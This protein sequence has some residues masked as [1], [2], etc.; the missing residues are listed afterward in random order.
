M[1]IIALLFSHR[2]LKILTTSAI[3]FSE[4]T[5]LDHKVFNHPV[6]LAA[7]VPLSFRLLGQLEE[8][9]RSLWHSLSEETDYNGTNSLASS[10]DVEGYLD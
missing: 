6:E 9:I 4:I 5:T 2:G 10:L 8:I 7:L 3:S 1:L